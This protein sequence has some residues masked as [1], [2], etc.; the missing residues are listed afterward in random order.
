MKP[1]LVVVAALLA[2]LVPA[3]VTSSWVGA[4]GERLEA[5]LAAEEAGAG[6]EPVA[7]AAAA[8][9]GYC[10][11]EL[12]SILRRVLQS[13]GLLSGAPERGCQPATAAQVASLSG[14]DF[15]ALF[16]PMASRAGVVQFDASSSELDA[17]DRTLIDEVFT[18][19]RGASYFF[20]VARA[21]PDGNAE[22]NAELSRQRAQTVLDYLRT[23]FDDPDLDREVG[24]LWLGEEFAQLDT[25]FCN[26]KRSGTGPCDEKQLNRS[27]FLT[28]VDCTL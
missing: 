22:D 18:D 19:Q 21:S 4:A 8:N 27:A 20:V 3:V 12:Q 5:S 11:P 25:G 6:A 28:W 1:A 13:C 14:G 16:L 10:T 7:V 9:A 23:R 15:N 24:L 2:I 26:W 17:A